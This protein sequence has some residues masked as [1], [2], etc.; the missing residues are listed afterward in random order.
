[1]KAQA[2]SGPFVPATSSGMTKDF[3]A[4]AEGNYGF[5]C[6]IHAI[7]GMNGAVFVEP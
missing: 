5:Y 3:T 2:A 6:E 1:M 4:S 7:G